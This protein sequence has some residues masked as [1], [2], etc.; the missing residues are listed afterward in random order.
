MDAMSGLLGDIA[1]GGAG[2]LFSSH[3]LDIVEHLCEDVVVIDGGHVMLT[4]DLDAI[5]DA[6][7]DRYLEITVARDPERLLHLRMPP[8]W[9]MTA[10]GSACASPCRR[11][12]DAARG[13]RW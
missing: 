8:S 4:G 2:V 6:A 1:R 13:C 10:T 5:R 9:P 7:P 12:G 3:Q 11:P